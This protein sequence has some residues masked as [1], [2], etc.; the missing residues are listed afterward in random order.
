[1][2]D[3]LPA[4]FQV[5]DDLPD[6]FSVEK[7]GGITGWLSSF[8]DEEAQKRAAEPGIARKMLYGTAELG[9]TMLGQGAPTHAFDPTTGEVHVS[10]EL[11]R[12]GVEGALTAELGSAIP[13][14]IPRR[15]RQSLLG[16]QIFQKA[17]RL[18][19][20]NQQ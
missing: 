1:M 3:D 4:G 20:Q 6:G 9:K 17:S 16:F 18:K 14:V 13:K 19:R 2:Y 10:P 5:F 8:A 7:S 15:R 11:Q 12:A